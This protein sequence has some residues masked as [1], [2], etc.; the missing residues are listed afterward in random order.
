MLHYK[1]VSGEKITD[2]L[3]DEV[4]ALFDTS[5]GDWS[6]DHAPSANLA[7]QAIIFPRKKYVEYFRGSE[8]YVGECE[9]ALCYDDDKLVGEAVYANKNTTRGM[10]A[11]V[12]QLV[13]HRDY[14]RRGI[15]SALLYSI[16]GFSDYYAWGIVTSNPCTVKTLEKAT[17]RQCSAIETI[18]NKH[19]LVREVLSDIRFL[20]ETR[21]SWVVNVTGKTGESRIRTGFATDRQEA[22][23]ALSEVESRLGRIGPKDEWLAFVFNSQE[24]T[25]DD[26]LKRMLDESNLIV[27]DAYMRMSAQHQKWSKQAEAEIDAILKMVPITVSA[28][29]CD[30]GAGSG[31]H[32]KVLKQRG[33]NNVTGI[34]FVTGGDCDLVQF[35]DCRTWKGAYRF[36]MILCLYDVIGSFRSLTDNRAI[37]ANI[38]DNLKPGG[39]A[40]ISVMNLSFRGMGVAKVVGSQSDELYRALRRLKPSTNMADTGEVFDGRFALVDK[41][42]GLVY[43]KEQ[44]GGDDSRLRREMIVVDRRFTMESIQDL[45]R[46]VGF[47]IVSSRYVRAGFEAPPLFY[48]FWPSRWGKGILL[49]L[50]ARRCIR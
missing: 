29:V 22:S 38:K 33:F 20:D 1:T 6:V 7:G 11:L 4:K 14:R 24:V 39:M 50:S 44:F 32:V 18:K 48:R 5:Y 28:S 41:D 15:G 21:D 37:L 46:S 35:G 17:Y 34:D 12:V 45:C 25:S 2:A 36:D 10:V 19:F 30:F 43:R 8:E 47:D 42:E 49:V 16:W 40:V 31:R 3:I 13:V 23:S 9:I 27:R 26:G